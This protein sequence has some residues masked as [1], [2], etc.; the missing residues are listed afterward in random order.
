MEKIYYVTGYKSNETDSII[1]GHQTQ[2]MLLEEA[3]DIPSDVARR[4]KQAIVRLKPIVK[5]VYRLN[6][7]KDSAKEY[8][9]TIAAINNDSVEA[10]LTAERRFRAYVLEFDMFLDYWESYIAHHKRIDGVSDDALV[11]EYKKLFKFLTTSAYD[12]HVEYQ[13][14]DLIRNQTAHVQSPVNRIHIEIDGNEMFS[15]RDILLSKCKSGPNKQKILKNQD[16]EIALGPIVKITSKC[17][18]DIHD[19]LMDFQIDK[20]VVDECKAMLTT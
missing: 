10:A 6:A 8:F 17:L 12:H 1:N 2:K 9:D 18:S 3:K 13:L 11:A 20:L 16:R 14:L 7:V 4:I 19:G 15:D 5:N